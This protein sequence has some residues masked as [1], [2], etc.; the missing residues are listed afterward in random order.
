[1]V[2]EA[3]EIYEKNG[4]IPDINDLVW[5]MKDN[6]TC[7]KYNPFSSGSF[8]PLI[9]CKGVYSRQVIKK[10]PKYSREYRNE[11]VFQTFTN[12]GTTYN[13]KDPHRGIG[14]IC[15]E[16][17]INVVGAHKCFS[18]D[19]DYEKKAK[20]NKIELILREVTVEKE[21]ESDWGDVWDYVIKSQ[22]QSDV[23]YTGTMTLGPN[24][25]PR[26]ESVMIMPQPHHLENTELDE[27]ARK[28]MENYATSAHKQLAEQV[29]EQHSLHEPPDIPQDMEITPDLTGDDTVNNKDLETPLNDEHIS[30]WS[31]RTDRLSSFDKD[32]I[33]NLMHGAVQLIDDHDQ[34]PTKLTST[35]LMNKIIE[36]YNMHLMD[37]HRS[38]VMFSE[39]QPNTNSLSQKMT[40]MGYQLI[41]DHRFLPFIQ[42][43]LS[44]SRT[45]LRYT[46]EGLDEREIGNVVNFNKLKTIT[47][48]V[49]ASNNRTIKVFRKTGDLWRMMFANVQ[50]GKVFEE[51]VHLTALFIEYYADKLAQKDIVYPAYSELMENMSPEK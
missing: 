16:D 31:V 11:S 10:K 47:I 25:N 1:M 8:T 39:I 32:T 19:T 48:Q 46:S 23:M 22:L 18:Q 45:L 43:K 44:T 51:I 5:L 42:S 12:T 28:R 26:P 41:Y 2:S 21:E 37:R 40:G 20:M 30:D 7:L 29:R 38:E 36:S 9:P 15:F 17:I 35:N 33:T 4:Y 14:I 27:Q 49:A 50:N 13:V 34:D 3:Q 24:F 6:K